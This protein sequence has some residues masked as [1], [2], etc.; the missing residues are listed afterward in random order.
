MSNTT[1]TRRLTVSEHHSFQPEFPERF[2]WSLAINGRH[3]ELCNQLAET[4]VLRRSKWT[5]AGQPG[6]DPLI[7]GLQ[8]GLRLMAGTVVWRVMQVQTAAPI[9]PAPPVDAPPAPDEL[10]KRRAPRP[11][12]AKRQNEKPRKLE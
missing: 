11:D 6:I 12:P 5:D 9:D 4:I 1:E 3:K 2:D 10:P 7:P 8:E